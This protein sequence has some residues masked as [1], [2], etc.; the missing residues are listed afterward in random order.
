MTVVTKQAWLDSAPWID[1]PDADI[2]AYL[3]RLDEDPGFDLRSA[4][5]CWRRDGVVVF[6]QA[7]EPALLDAFEAD[8]QELR[9]AG[10]NSVDYAAITPE[11]VKI[12]P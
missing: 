12:R 10:F 5:E 8:L 1:R 3:A 11:T 9:T 6:E 7:I 4:L 2:D